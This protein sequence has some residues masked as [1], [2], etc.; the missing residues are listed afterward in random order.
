MLQ[1]LNDLRFF[2]YAASVISALA[3]LVPVLLRY[4]IGLNGGLACW[5]LSVVTGWRL[6]C[7]IDRKL[8]R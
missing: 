5:L 1:E 7:L 3:F 6:G 4:A 8:S 2:W